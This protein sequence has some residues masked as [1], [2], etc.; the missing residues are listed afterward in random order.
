MTTLFVLLPADREFDAVLADMA[1][2]ARAGLASA[3]LRRY[4]R[5]DGAA[6]LRSLVRDGRDPSATRWRR[7]MVL[8]AMVGAILGMIVNGVLAGAFG[9]L[10]GLIEIALPLGF[11]LGAFLGGF[12]AAM[13]GTQV[14]RDE[15]RTLLAT[16][17]PGDVLLQWTLADAVSL[18]AVAA[19]FQRMGLRCVVI[20][21]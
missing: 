18:R 14:A 3:K 15:L 8:A 17:L 11:V 20:G 5:A 16:A 4:P 13:S 7:G 21:S 10:G 12:T 1:T 9:M 6:H 2:P 19:Q